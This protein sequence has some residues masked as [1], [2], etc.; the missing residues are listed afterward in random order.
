MNNTAEIAS[1]AIAKHKFSNKLVYLPL[2]LVPLLLI[3]SEVIKPWIRPWYYLREGNSLLDQNQAQDS[4]NK[5][6]Q[7]INLQRDSAT[8]WKGRGDALFTLGRYSGALEAYDQAIAIEPAN[9]KA[10]NNQGKI[11]Y[12][13]ENCHRRS[14]LINKRL[15][16]SLITLMPGVVRV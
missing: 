9:V 4:L 3:V 14:K 16:S 11:L 13:Q 6:Q 15:K 8:A 10:L 1:Q 2:I 5:F 7:V 12:Q